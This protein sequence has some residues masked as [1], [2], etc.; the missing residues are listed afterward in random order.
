[1][2]VFY[3]VLYCL[4]CVSSICQRSIIVM[5]IGMCLH[6][7]ITNTFFLDIEL[8][9]INDYTGKLI[10]VRKNGRGGKQYKNQCFLTRI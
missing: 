4:C 8:R 5:K 9:K 7:A 10:F 3:D 1:M 6:Y 2:R